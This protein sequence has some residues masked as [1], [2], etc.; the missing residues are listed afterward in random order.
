MPINKFGNSLD[1]NENK[2]DTSHFV[3]KLYLRPKYLES[4]IEED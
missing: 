3:Q 1:N 4:N 2:M